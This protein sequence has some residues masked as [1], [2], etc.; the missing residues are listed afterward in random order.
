MTRHLL[1]ILCTGHWRKFGREMILIV[2][3]KSIQMWRNQ[4]SAGFISCLKYIKGCILFQVGPLSLTLVFMQKIFLH[5]QIFILNLLWQKLSHTSR[6]NNF[7]RKL[8]NLPKLPDDVILCTTDVVGLYSNIP[9]EEGLLFLKKALDK[10]R[11]KLC[12]LNLLLNWR[13]SF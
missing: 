13:K 6:V 11:N 4:N 2:I 1:Q 9:N 8:Q 12:P 3:V 7:L 10:R 5:F